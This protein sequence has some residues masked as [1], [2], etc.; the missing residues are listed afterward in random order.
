MQ[1]ARG[2]RRA[3]VRLYSAKS[4]RVGGGGGSAANE[5]PA[6]L[7]DA[8]RVDGGPCVTAGGPRRTGVRLYSAKSVRV[9]GGGGSAANECPAPLGVAVWFLLSRQTVL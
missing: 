8:G 1:A 3:G 5:C 4:V 7:G 2:P 6:P 9:G